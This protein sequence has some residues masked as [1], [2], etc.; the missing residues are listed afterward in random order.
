MSNIGQST[1][2]LSEYTDKKSNYAAQVAPLRYM[3]DFSPLN[4]TI[5]GTKYN[6]TLAIKKA[7]ISAQVAAKTCIEKLNTDDFKA[8]ENRLSDGNKKMVKHLAKSYLEFI[9]KLKARQEQTS[10]TNNGEKV[11][12]FAALGLEFAHTCFLG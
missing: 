5:N 4:M 3:A 1:R 7:G 8:V 6:N 11:D 10:I 9:K 2:L 12:T